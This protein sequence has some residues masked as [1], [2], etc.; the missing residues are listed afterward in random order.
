MARRHEYGALSAGDD[1]AG[2]D[3]RQRGPV[4]ARLVRADEDTVRDVIHRFNQ[5]GPARRDPR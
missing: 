1:R 5:I 2:L 4:I 3:R